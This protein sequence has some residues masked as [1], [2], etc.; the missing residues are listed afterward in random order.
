MARGSTGGSGDAPHDEGDRRGYRTQGDELQAPA[1]VAG[2]LGVW[3][4]IGGADDPIGSGRNL[5]H[6]PQVVAGVGW[7]GLVLTLV[8]RGAGVNTEQQSSGQDEGDNRSAY[9]PA[10]P[11][12]H[13]LDPGRYRVTSPVEAL[14]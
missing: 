5:V 8:C 10:S 13:G 3:S 9:A 6:G 2:V 12:S 7:E 4:G 14:R 1:P 11:S